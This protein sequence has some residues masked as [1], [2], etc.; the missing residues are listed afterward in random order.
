[1]KREAVRPLYGLASERFPP[2]SLVVA[3]ASAVA[4]QSGASA[5]RLQSRSLRGPAW[6]GPLAWLAHREGRRNQITQSLGRGLAIPELASRLRGHHAQPPL[7]V[8]PT[9]EA[10]Q[11][12]GALLFGQRRRRAH[13][14]PY[15]DPRGR[16]VDVLT[17]GPAGARRSKFQLGEREQERGCDLEITVWHPRKLALLTHGFSQVYVSPP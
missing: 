14:P 16:G 7:A 3:G 8:Q 13:V 2:A 11:K 1:M 6:L 17:A 12:P 5:L 9:G 15:L 4:F 10:C